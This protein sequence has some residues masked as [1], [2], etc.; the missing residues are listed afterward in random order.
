MRKSVRR[1]GVAGFVLAVSATLSAPGAM[2]DEADP[3]LA[4][5]CDATLRDGSGQALTLDAGAPLDQPGVVTV[6]T[7]SD[8]APTGPDQRKPLVPLPV[9]DLAKVLRLGDTPVVG[10][11]ATDQVCPGAQ[12]TVNALSRVTQSVVSGEQLDPPSTGEPAPQPG[13]PTPPPGTP[14]PG[15]TSPAPGA[16]GAIVPASFVPGEFLPGSGIAP[17]SLSALI[18]PGAVAPAAPG[19]VPPP[20]TPPVVTQNSGTAEAMPST[21][22]PARLP[23]IIAVFALAIVAAALTRSWM[24]RA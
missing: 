22:A 19:L 11:L 24:R 23:L 8:S 18:Q 4:G 1:A 15:T 20:G 10:D 9:T 5:S 16:N 7:G 21:T 13:A 17:P 12:N 2:A 3:A 6:G 14:A